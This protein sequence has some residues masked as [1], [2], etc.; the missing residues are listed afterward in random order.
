MAASH[1]ACKI[2]VKEI[3]QDGGKERGICASFDAVS[4]WPVRVSTQLLQFEFR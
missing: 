1:L 2:D 4:M 3:S